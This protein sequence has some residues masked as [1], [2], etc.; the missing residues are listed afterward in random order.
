M[1]PQGTLWHFGWVLACKV[2]RWC[3]A[4]GIAGSASR[5]M[6]CPAS[7]ISSPK[8]IIHV[9]AQGGL[10]IGLTLVR[11]LVQLHGGTIQARSED[12]GKEASLSSAFLGKIPIDISTAE[13]VIYTPVYFGRQAFPS[14][15]CQR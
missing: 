7:S 1:A 4:C 11:N 3:C 5:L 10:G 12:R 15:A 14:G 6:Q 2:M 8:R 9:G 13:R